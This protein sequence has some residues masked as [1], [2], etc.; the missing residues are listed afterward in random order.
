MNIRAKYGVFRAEMEFKNYESFVAARMNGTIPKL[1]RINLVNFI[2]YLFTYPNAFGK[3]MCNIANK[4]H[5]HDEGNCWYC[6]RCGAGGKLIRRT[7]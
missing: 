5:I 7:R 2:L 3:L 6:T 4:H 1:K